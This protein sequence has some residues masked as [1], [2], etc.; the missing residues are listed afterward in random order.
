MAS[1]VSVGTEFKIILPLKAEEPNTGEFESGDSRRR[2]DLMA[3]KSRIRNSSLILLSML[4]EI[5]GKQVLWSDDFDAK[6]EELH[7]VLQ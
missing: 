7:L 1:K 3:L 4:E 5:K 2:P 6:E